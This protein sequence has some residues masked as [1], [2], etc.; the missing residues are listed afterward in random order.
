LCKG[1]QSWGQNR[2]FKDYERSLWLRGQ[3]LTSEISKQEA[4]VKLIPMTSSLRP[5]RHPVCRKCSST[6]SLV[7]KESP[8]SGRWGHYFICPQHCEVDR[9]AGSQ[10]I[11]I[12]RWCSKPM[13]LHVGRFGKWKGVSIWYCKIDVYPQSASS[14]PLR[15]R[16]ET[17][18]PAPRPEP[19][20]ENPWPSLSRKLARNNPPPKNVRRVVPRPE[21]PLGKRPV[22]PGTMHKRGDGTQ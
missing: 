22:D 21:E 1:S 2:S 20:P 10:E 12:C 15:T 4:W 13:T 14:E 16:P 3:R 9:T 18:P 8:R 17:S 6:M 19:P 5:S 11:P 7:P